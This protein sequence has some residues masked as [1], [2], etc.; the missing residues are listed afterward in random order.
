[1]YLLALQ[2]AKKLNRTE[3]SSKAEAGCGRSQISFDQRPV[4]AYTSTVHEV[5]MYSLSYT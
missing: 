5:M 2:R 4:Q 3:E 1:M